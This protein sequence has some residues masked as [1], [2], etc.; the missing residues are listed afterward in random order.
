[1]PE[2]RILRPEEVVSAK[3]EDI[4]QEVFDAFNAAIAKHWDGQRAKFTQQEV[5]KAIDFA[6][7]VIIKNRWL[8]VEPSYR[9]CG[10]NVEYDKPGFNENYKATFCFTKGFCKV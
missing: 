10:W 4:P 2:K 1:M 5:V 3:T 9:A 7:D 6:P 8:D